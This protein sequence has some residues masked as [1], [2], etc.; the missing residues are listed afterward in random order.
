MQNMKL[1]CFKKRYLL[2]FLAVLI[3]FGSIVGLYLG[4]HNIDY[5][6]ENVLY[7]VTNINS[8]TYN[9]ILIHFFVVTISIITSFIGIGIPF[10][11]TLIFY[12]GM[13]IGFLIGLF[14]ITYGLK[15]I[16]F[17]L[18]FLIITKLI[19]LIIL[20]FLFSKCLNIARKMIGKF[21]Y[22][23]DPSILVK[24]LLKGC[25]CLTGMLLLYDTLLVLIGNKVISIFQFLL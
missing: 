4:I 11:C 2:L 14:S 9:Y 20:V 12:E 15:G 6:K 16:L 19:Y 1:Y 25:I 18:I 10:L 13:S 5:L 23:T 17:S 22:K 21:I 8:Q 24:H 7:Y 3:C